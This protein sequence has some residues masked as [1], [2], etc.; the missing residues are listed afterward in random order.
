LALGID[1]VK[2]K[3]SGVEHAD[4]ITVD[5]HKLGFIPYPCSAIIFHNQS[6]LE[7]IAINAPY[8]GSGANTIEGSRPG[9]GIAG[10]WVALR[11][12]GRDGYNRIIAR[13]IDLT[14]NLSGR[15]EDAGF[16]VLHEID[17]N[18][19]CFSLKIDG[20]SRRRI[21]KLID[22][23]HTRITA[24]GRY[25]LGKVDDLCGVFVKNKPWQTDSERVS[26]EA[27]KV[28]IMNPYTTE[29]DLESLVS[30][31]SEKRK[32]AAEP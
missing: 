10:L 3:A 26:I 27:I 31:L 13:C 18:T 17:L 4:S 28:W 8:V 29:Q 7:E 23:L 24:E 12:L 14:K 6:D 2:E 9:S 22:D 25:L 21:N 32:R 19:V 5:P 30:D 20:K 15:L 1:E 16:H 11:T